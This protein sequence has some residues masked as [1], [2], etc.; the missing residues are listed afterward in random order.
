LPSPR[1]H[2]DMWAEHDRGEHGW[3]L[4]LELGD[5]P[6]DVPPISS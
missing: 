1:W 3:S 2:D 4:T 6:A 5:E